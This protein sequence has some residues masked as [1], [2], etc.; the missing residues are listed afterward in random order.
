MTENSISPIPQPSSP[1][2]VRGMFLDDDGAPSFS[3]VASG[4]SLVC[5]VIWVTSLVIATH[6]LPDLT[7]LSLYISAFYGANRVAAAFS[8][9]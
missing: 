5:S 4:I 2:F 3:R 6:Q 7:G 8:R 9:T 1:S